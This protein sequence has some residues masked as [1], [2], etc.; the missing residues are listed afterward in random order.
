[1]SVPNKKSTRLY[2]QI[3][4]LPDTLIGEIIDG[5]IVVSPRPSGPN[6]LVAS[7]LGGELEGPFYKGRGGGPGGWWILAEPEVEFE[8]E[9]QHFVPDLAGWR[10]VRMPHVPDG[11]IFT[12]VPDWV[13]EVVSPSSKRHDRVEKFNV[14]AKHS[15]G[16]YWI[17]DPEAKTV[18]TFKLDRGAWRSAGAFAGSGKIRAEPFE[19]VEIDM[20]WLWPSTSGPPDSKAEKPE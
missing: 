17:V 3:M 9:V 14:Y 8:N 1:M 10:K 19:V 18:E 15:V 13:C 7:A 4:A 6:I 11:H 16:Y 20:H 12:V 2:D 5:E